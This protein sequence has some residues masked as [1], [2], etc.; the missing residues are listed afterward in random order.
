MDPKVTKSL[1]KDKIY[2]KIKGLDVLD[3]F[4]ETIWK[5]FIVHHINIQL[6]CFH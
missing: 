3:F 5:S 4:T 2:D 1:S 6:Q